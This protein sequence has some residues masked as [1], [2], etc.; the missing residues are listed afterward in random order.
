MYLFLYPTAVD[1]TA[2]R[3]VFSCTYDMLFVSTDDGP[4]AG[5]SRGHAYVFCRFGFGLSPYFPLVIILVRFR[6]LFC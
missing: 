2:H 6:F 4:P 5:P 1:D 3:E